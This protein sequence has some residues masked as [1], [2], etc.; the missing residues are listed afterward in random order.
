VGVNRCNCDW[1]YGML[2]LTDATVTGCTGCGSYKM[3]L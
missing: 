1:M 3:Q 2:E